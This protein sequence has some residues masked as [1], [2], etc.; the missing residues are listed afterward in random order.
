MSCLMFWL[1]ILEKCMENGQWATCYFSLCTSALHINFSAMYADLHGHF[2]FFFHKWLFVFTV[3]M[4]T[5][6][7]EWSLPTMGS[8]GASLGILSDTSCALAPT[9]TQGACVCVRVCVCVCVCVCVRVRVCVCVCV[10]RF[11]CFQ[12]GWDGCGQ[13]LDQRHIK[14]SILEKHK[15]LVCLCTSLCMSMCVKFSLSWLQ[16]VLVS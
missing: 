8:S 14:P 6:L 4:S 9:T 7:V 5:R 1:A 12:T 10:H 11:P 3:G 13:P 16:Q 15:H 2:F